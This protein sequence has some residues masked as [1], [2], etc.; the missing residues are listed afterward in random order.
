ML[1]QHQLKLTRFGWKNSNELSG[2]SAKHYQLQV[3]LS[4]ETANLV[5]LM[6]ALE[7]YSPYIEIGDFVLTMKQQ[8]AQ[9]LGQVRG[10]LTLHLYANNKPAS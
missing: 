3:F 2:F 8:K 9:K 10:N 6:A 7:Q 1:E 5:K 4:G